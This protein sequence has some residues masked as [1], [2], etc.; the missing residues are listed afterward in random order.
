LQKPVG[1]D[2]FWAYHY[3]HLEL[4]EQYVRAKLRERGVGN[5]G[6]KNSLIFSRLPGFIKSAKNREGILKL[7]HELQVK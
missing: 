1:D 2:L 5:K 6:S 3:D 4:L 7:I